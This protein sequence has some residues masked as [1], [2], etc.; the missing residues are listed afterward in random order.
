MG[1]EIINWNKQR[2]KMDQEWLKMYCENLIYEFYFF[3]VM[4]NR[5][6]INR[7]SYSYNTN[8]LLIVFYFNCS[9]VFHNPK[10]AYR[11]II[12]TKWNK[13]LKILSAYNT[14]QFL[15][16][17]SVN[18][19]EERILFVYFT[20]CIFEFCFLLFVVVLTYKYSLVI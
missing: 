14:S 7:F 19:I 2:T 1:N 11:T 15:L 17:L 5:R 8:V 13:F 12:G 4:E 3:D 6:K 10:K 16:T 20:K 9:A 18:C